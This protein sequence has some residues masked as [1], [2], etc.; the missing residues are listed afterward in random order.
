MDNSLIID[1]YDNSIH[2][3]ESRIPPWNNWIKSNNGAAAELLWEKWGADIHI[4]TGQLQFVNLEH[5][6]EWLI[7]WS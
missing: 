4:Q 6:M 5:K 1:L 2:W 3:P 7:A